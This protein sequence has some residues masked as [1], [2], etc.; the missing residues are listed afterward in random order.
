MTYERIGDLE[1]SDEVEYMGI[2]FY[3]YVFIKCYSEKL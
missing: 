2:H 3:Y 1:T